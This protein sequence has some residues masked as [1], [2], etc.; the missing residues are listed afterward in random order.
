MEND[1]AACSSANLTKE[2]ERCKCFYSA[3]NFYANSNYKK[4]KKKNFY[5]NCCFYGP[6]YRC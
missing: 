4:K 1:F 3:P 5:A 6:L 2:S